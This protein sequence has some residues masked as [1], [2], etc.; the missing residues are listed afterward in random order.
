MDALDSFHACV[1]PSILTRVERM[2]DGTLASVLFE[3]LQNARR[4]GAKRVS[5]QTE[6]VGDNRCR[7][8]VEDDGC[9][10]QDFRTLFACGRSDWNQRIE[11]A[12]DPAGMG[13]YSLSPRDVVVES[14]GYRVEVGR[15][16]WFGRSAIDVRAAP[17]FRGTRISFESGSIELLTVESVARYGPLDVEFNGQRIKRCDFLSDHGGELLAKRHLPEL[18]VRVVLCGYAN[19]WETRG[20]ANF[21]GKTLSFRCLLLDGYNDPCIR[22]DFTG[23]ATKLAMVL[24]GRNEFVQNEAYRQLTAAAQKMAFE[25]VRAPHLLHFSA[26][27]RAREMGVDLPEADFDSFVNSHEI[28]LSAYSKPGSGPAVLVGADDRNLGF[29]SANGSLPFK[30]VRADQ[31]YA[32]YSWYD[33]LRKIDSVEVE[34]EDD[35]IGEFG[36]AHH[37]LV[38]AEKITVTIRFLNETEPLVLDVPAAFDDNDYRLLLT[39]AASDIPSRDLFD[40]TGGYADDVDSGSGEEQTRLFE[41]GLDAFFDHLV[42]RGEEDTFYRKLTNAIRYERVGR[43][44]ELSRVDLTLGGDLVLTWKDGVTKT[45]AAPSSKSDAEEEANGTSGNE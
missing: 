41:E 26:W 32:G 33:S 18:G 43:S 7:V 3:L 4:S 27:Q 23:E 13:F 11:E 19:R 20:L 35:G 22:V 15:Q 44:V 12:E 30:P 2:F 17:Y 28:R 39:P 9:G 34:Y 25:T 42:G 16:Q 38:G 31:N 36:A 45:V 5:I 1:D 24:P 29:L 10:I 40:L 14:L 21:H 8:V 6:P 37:T